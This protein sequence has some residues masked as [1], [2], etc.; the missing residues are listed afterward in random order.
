MWNGLGQ[1]IQRRIVIIAEIQI[2]DSRAHGAM[3]LM[4]Q[5]KP[6]I[7]LSANVFIALYNIFQ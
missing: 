7:F 5:L 2:A 1:I 4:T 3:L 6:A